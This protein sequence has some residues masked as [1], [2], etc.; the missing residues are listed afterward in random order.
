[1][2]VITK[3]LLLDPGMAR[4]F[5]HNYAYNHAFGKAFRQEKLTVRYYF[6]NTL[7]QELEEEFPDSSAC[8]NWFLFQEIA[9]VR[10]TPEYFQ[11]SAKAFCSELQSCVS[12]ETGADSLVFAHTLDPTALLGIALWYCMQEEDK[13][14]A[15]S[16]SVMLGVDAT[17]ECRERLEAS[18]ALLRR[19]PRV[20][21]F[22]GTRAVG[23]MLTD[24][25]GQSCPMLPTPLPERPEQYNANSQIG[26]FVFGLAGD[27][28]PGKNL[29]IVPSVLALYLKRGG[30]GNFV[31]QMT[32]T[33]EEIHP[34]A[35]ALHDLS[36]L[37]PEKI[38]LHIRYLGEEAYY[39]NLA[40]F[41]ALLLPYTASEYTR[42]RPSGLAIEAAAM[43]VPVVAAGGGFIEEELARLNNGS[44]FVAKPTRELLV[45]GMFC[46][47]QEWEKRKCLALRAAPAYCAHHDIRSWIRTMLSEG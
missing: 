35:L 24:L 23:D 37:Y 29:H 15:L 43:A 17:R 20:R 8:F 34:V 46:F 47:E 12:P 40:S 13:R 1:M 31:I 45:E 28:R 4:L 22:G 19:M 38:T 30:L 18:C 10:D 41:S 9:R 2:S 27:W 44:L 32:P 33:D 7:P 39:A 3:I 25:M 42:Y 14:P 11:S 6:N 26:T 36:L 21:L 16:L 5:G